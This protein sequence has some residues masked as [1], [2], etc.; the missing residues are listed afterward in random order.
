MFD[1]ER[2]TY[3]PVTGLRTGRYGAGASTSSICYLVGDTL[4]DTGPA[5]RWRVLRTFADAHADRIERIVLTHHHEDHVGNAAYLQDRLDVPVYAPEASLERLADPPS[6]PVYRR[7]AWGTPAPVEAEPVP[8]ELALPEGHTLQTIAAPGHADDMVCY[9]IPEIG[10][11]FAG[12]LYVTRRPDHLRADE[13]IP[14]LM[15]SIRDVLLRSVEVVF[16]AHRGVVED[17]E[18]ALRE[19]VKYLEALSGVVQRRHA[20]GQAVDRITREM[21]GREGW[22]RYLTGGEF[23][24]ENLVQ[25]CLQR[26]TPAVDAEEGIVDADGNLL[27]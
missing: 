18:Q 13:D 6:L 10:W 19:K 25:S 15:Q 2:I 5:N 26:P 16:C 20:E 14:R 11:L 17:G 4:I 8:E 9:Y 22:L 24:K 12:D 3:G 1:S 7:L 27:H 21:L 23:A